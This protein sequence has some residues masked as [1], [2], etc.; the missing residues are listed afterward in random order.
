MKK[1]QLKKII[2]EEIKST[3]NKTQAQD[4]AILAVQDLARNFQAAQR[5]FLDIKNCKVKESFKTMPMKGSLGRCLLI[6]LRSGMQ[7][8]KLLML[9][10]SI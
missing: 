1:S 9:C 2:K 7:N 4:D 10:I 8:P 6:L 3:F 5:D